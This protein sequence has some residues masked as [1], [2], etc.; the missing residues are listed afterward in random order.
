MKH[1]K[2][3]KKTCLVCGSDDVMPFLEIWNNVVD[4]NHLLSSQREALQV[5]RADIRLAFCRHCGHIF[6]KAFKPSLLK[7]N[8]CHESALQYSRRIQSYDRDLASHLIEDYDTW[9]KDVMSW[10][11]ME[12]QRR[13]NLAA[14]NL[15]RRLKAEELWEPWKERF[16]QLRAEG[17]AMAEVGI[18]VCL[19]KL[20]G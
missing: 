17:V 7:R 19:L 3:I 8:E 9:G 14:G 1:A 11:T 6:N 10:R 18:D 5:P 20:V 4:C 13:L 2:A 12:D 15:K 16:R